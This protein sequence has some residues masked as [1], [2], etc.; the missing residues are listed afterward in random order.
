MNGVVK[1]G[2]AEILEKQGEPECRS[3]VLHS[4]KKGG[5][6]KKRHRQSDGMCS[7]FSKSTHICQHTCT[8]ATDQ[9][10]V[11]EEGQGSVFCVLLPSPS[12]KGNMETIRTINIGRRKQGIMY[13]CNRTGYQLT[14]KE[15]PYT[16]YS[17]NLM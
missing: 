1:F 9:E 5:R 14:R 8:V 17:C 4:L 11:V 3:G 15:Y 6:V 13:T 2:R 16:L 12:T 10:N 7:Q